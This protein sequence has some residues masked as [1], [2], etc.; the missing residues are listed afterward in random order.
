MYNLFLHL[1][2]ENLATPLH[3][4]RVNMSYVGYTVGFY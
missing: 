2:Y 3:A 1:N 4:T